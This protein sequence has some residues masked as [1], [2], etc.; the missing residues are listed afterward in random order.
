M[1]GRGQF[2]G[3]FRKGAAGAILAAEKPLPAIG[4]DPWIGVERDNAYVHWKGIFKGLSGYAKANR[5]VALRVANTLRLSAELALDCPDHDEYLSGRMLFHNR[6]AVPSNAPSVRFFGPAV[7]KGNN[8]HRVIWTMMETACVHPI[9]IGLMN[10]HYHEAWTPTEWNKRTFQESGLKIPC[11]VMP[12]GIDPFIYRPGNK[13]RLPPAQLI[14]TEAAGR[15]ETPN[16]FL[17]LYCFLPSWRKGAD[18]ILKA[19]EIAFGGD[20]GVGLVLNLSHSTLKDTVTN[21]VYPHMRA[22]VW[23]LKGNFSEWQM[24]DLYRSVDAYVCTSRG[25]G[26]NLPAMEASACGTPAVLPDN[27]VHAELFGKACHLFQ[28]DGVERCPDSEVISPWY[29]GMAFSY[30][31]HPALERL[32]AQLRHVRDN[33][34]EVR[35]KA[36]QFSSDIRA[37]R[38]WDRASHGVIERLLEIQG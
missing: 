20:P 27:S 30:Y 34:P 29:E 2:D 12:L 31:G 15:M 3:P 37:N 35:E 26:W 33:Y 24:A 8:R 18:V 16:G 22:P 10:E 25:E 17:F 5:E 38:T 9:M 1:S 32:V 23:V 7:E 13:K 4:P 21:Q 6:V 11:R 36:L 14:T 19:F 28:D